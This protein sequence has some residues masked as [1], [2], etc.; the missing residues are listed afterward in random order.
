MARVSSTPKH[1]NGEKDMTMN[2]TL[3]KAGQK[4]SQLEDWCGRAW[5][6]R[7]CLVRA[8]IEEK[9]SSKR[10]LRRPRLRWEDCV[11]YDAEKVGPANY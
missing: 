6:K 4:K 1:E 8:T 5:T 3:S 11:K 7:G 10:P 9:P 2:R